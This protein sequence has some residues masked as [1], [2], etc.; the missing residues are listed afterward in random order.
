MGQ[1]REQLAGKELDETKVSD[2]RRR[3]TEGEKALAE[4]RAVYLAVQGSQNSLSKEIGT[5]E[6]RAEEAKKSFTEL[7]KAASE[8]EK[9]LAG[10]K[11]EE[12]LIRKAAAE[13]AALEAGA[14]IKSLSL[15]VE[16]AEDGMKRLSPE[17]LEMPCLQAAAGQRRNNPRCQRIQAG[18]CEK[19]GKAGSPCSP[20]IGKVRAV[21]KTG[22]PAQA[23]L[24]H[25]PK[26]VPS[27]Q[28]RFFSRRTGNKTRAF[29]QDG[30][31]IGCPGN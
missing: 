31:G 24:V 14:E 21:A 22:H 9:A 15:A 27:S 7:E 30:R 18:N 23:N 12:I 2:V 29:A 4:C 13:K 1:L 26:D 10:E 16:K 11:E 20:E 6:A 25:I 8:M 19:Q 17:T 3:K 28:A 5:A